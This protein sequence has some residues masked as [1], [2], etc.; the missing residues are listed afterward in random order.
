MTELTERID[1]TTHE[2]IGAAVK[3]HRTLGPGLLESAYVP[4]LTLELHR[5]NFDVALGVPVPINYEGIHID[6]GYRLDMIVN[7]LVVVEI[8]SVAQLAPIHDAQLLTYLKLSGY[9]IGLLMNF[10]VQMLT[11]GVRRRLN[12]NPAPRFVC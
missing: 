2:I 4:C 8:K 1:A 10:N 5:L 6:C 11:T 9:P 7:D 12:K 3:V